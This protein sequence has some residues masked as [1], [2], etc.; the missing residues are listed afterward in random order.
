M[1][2]SSEFGSLLSFIGLVVLVINAIG[3]S[4]TPAPSHVDTLGLAMAIS[5]SILAL[6]SRD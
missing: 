5:G 4:G 3:D 1:R 6:G 2:A